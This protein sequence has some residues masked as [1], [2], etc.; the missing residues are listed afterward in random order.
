MDYCKAVKNERIRKTYTNT[1]ESQ[2]YKT[3]TKKT[4]SQKVN[5]L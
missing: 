5:N 1:C 2:P 4:K 3:E